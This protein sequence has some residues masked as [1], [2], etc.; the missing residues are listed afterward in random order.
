MRTGVPGA[1]ASGRPRDCAAG[2]GKRHMHHVTLHGGAHGG[3]E[4][5]STAGLCENQQE[6]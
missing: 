4:G 1:R 3:V 6:S 2:I 5:A